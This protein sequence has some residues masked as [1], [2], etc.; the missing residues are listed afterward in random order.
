MKPMKIK[1]PA[2]P[3]VAIMLATAPA[4]AH[5]SFGA[6]YDVS[7]EITVKG[8]IVQV[9]L[10]SPHSFFFIEAADSTG[11]VQRWSIEGAAAGQFAQQGV[12]KDAFKVGDAVEVVANPARSAASFRGRLI[13]ITRTTDGKSWGGR[14]DE[15]FQ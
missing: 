2:L 12:T 5:H 1:L 13:K 15:T 3:A 9:S 14:A 11:T 10:R 4:Q 8:T 6:T 7:K